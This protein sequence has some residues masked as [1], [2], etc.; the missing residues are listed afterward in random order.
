MTVFVRG[1]DDAV[2]YRDYVGGSWGKWTSI[3]GKIP[4]GT[5]P[6][7]CS[8]G[9]GR[10]DVFVQGTNGALWHKWWNG[11]KWS[12]WESLGGKLTASPASVSPLGSGT[13]ISVSARGY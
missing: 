2:W 1:S 8:W 3:G 7:A 10:L 9:S 5:G 11:A 13:V 6:A 4:A 12:G